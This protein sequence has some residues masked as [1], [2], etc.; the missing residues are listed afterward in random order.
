[1]TMHATI[2]GFISGLLFGAAVFAIALLIRR[3]SLQRGLRVVAV[4]VASTLL[5][6]VPPPIV[7]LAR[8]E[9]I[10]IVQ[11][12]HAGANFFSPYVLLALVALIVGAFVAGR[13]NKVLQS[14]VPRPA[15]SART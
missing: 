12:G 13:S 15:D 7:L 8:A 6:L 9:Y 2:A 14:D 4:L 11:E 1:M 3:V 5:F 10:T